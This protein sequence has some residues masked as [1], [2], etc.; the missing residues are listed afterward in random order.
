MKSRKE[1]AD[2]TFGGSRHSFIRHSREPNFEI[3]S[4]FIF[5]LGF[6]AESKSGLLFSRES[7]G[8]FPETEC[9]DSIS[10]RPHIKP[11]FKLS[12]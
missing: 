12:I 8:S 6:R 9:A 2:V 10:G 3:L 7:F 1:F 4:T 11:S 5:S